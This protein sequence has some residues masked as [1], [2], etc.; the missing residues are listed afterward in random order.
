MP[1][2]EFD[3]SWPESIQTTHLYDRLEVWG[4]RFNAPYAEMYKCRRNETLQ[5]LKKY[6]PK[7]GNVLDL[8]AAGGNFSLAAAEQG[9]KVTWN[10][11]RADLAD[12]VRLKMS[13]HHNVNF[14]AGNI[15]ELGDQWH[16]SFDAIMA[17]EV[18]EHV[19]HPDEFLSQIAKLA[20][21]GA[22][23]IV[24]TPNGAY[25]KNDLPKFSD[26]PDPSVFEEIQFKPNSDGHIF[27]LYEDEMKAFGKDAGLKMVHYETFVNPLTAG[28]LKL[29]YLHK[30][31]PSTAIQFI[32]KISQKLPLQLK[33][34]I[35]GASLAVYMK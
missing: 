13:S 2:L 31:L 23:I 30:V 6:C 34:K 18:I 26:H 4:E 20:K 17:L 28:H 24:S 9:H 32:E 33:K 11:L 3:P 22:P 8:A 12:Y 19:A 16:N 10:D 1:P 29:R 25:L 14:V 5:A 7:P 35:M 15:F 27:L 21:P